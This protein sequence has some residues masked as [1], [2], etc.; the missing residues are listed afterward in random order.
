MIGGYTHGLF[1]EDLYE[2]SSGIKKTWIIELNDGTLNATE[3]PSL[4]FGRKDL[5]C[6]KM[7]DDFGN[8]VI[9]AAGGTGIGF[10]TTEVLNMTT[11]IWVKGLLADY[12]VLPMICMNQD[13]YN[14]RSQFA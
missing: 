3:G 6:G 4:I 10:S 7:I 14:C 8:I 1:D 11:G 12:Y 13:F 2:S 9:V 5:S